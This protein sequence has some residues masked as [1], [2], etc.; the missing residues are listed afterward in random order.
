MG[1]GLQEYIAG[2]NRSDL[3][4]TSKVWNTDHHPDAVRYSADMPHEGFKRNS[5]AAQWSCCRVLSPSM[6][7]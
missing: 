7:F 5:P 1:E 2:G 4:I 3:F 6:T